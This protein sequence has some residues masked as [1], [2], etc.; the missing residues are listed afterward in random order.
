MMPAHFLSRLLSL[1][2]LLVGV[3]A[4]A[5]MAESDVPRFKESACPFVNDDL[6]DVVRCGYLVVAENRAVDNGRTLHLAVAIIRSSAASPRSDPIVYLSGGPGGKNVEYV[7]RRAD[8]FFWNRY[9]E[10]RD[11]VFFDQRGTGFSEPRFC[12]EL[13]VALSTAV[14]RGISVEEQRNFEREAVLECRAKMLAAGIDF[15][16]YNSATSARDLDELRQALGYESWNLFGV[17]YGTRLALT[18]M[19][20]TPGGVRSVVLDSVSPPGSPSADS[21]HKLMRTLRLVFDQCAADRRCHAA[22]PTLEADFFSVVD[23]LE[24][25]PV[26][27]AMTDPIRFPDA[28]I[29]IN[30]TVFVAG[31]FQGLYEQAFVPFLPILVRELKAGNESML[32][33]MADS[34][35][36]DPHFV[37]QG[38]RYA[39]DCY[40]H[41]PYATA[42][43]LAEDRA[44]HPQ[45]AVFHNLSD[46]QAIC[47]A[48]HSVRAGP[49][50]LQAATS[51]I[52]TLVAAGEFDPITPPSYARLA[53]ERLRNATLFEVRG[54]SHGV[55]LH[56][57]CAQGIMQ[58]FLD[59]PLSPPDT[60][61]VASLQR[62]DFVTSAHANPGVYRLVR[63]IQELPG[64]ATVVGLGAKF[65]LIGSA[66]LVWPIAWLSRRR[67]RDNVETP[68][69]ARQARTLE[70]V[71][72]LLIVVFLAGLAWAIKA[73]IQQNVYLLAIGVGASA[74]PLF[75]LPWIVALLTLV[76]SAFV[77][78]AWKHRWW[79]IIGRIYFSLVAVA[80]AGFVLWAV[81]LGLI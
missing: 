43:A 5:A 49:A 48:W 51:D 24:A 28:R 69:A 58:A 27:L 44:A 67:S 40:E 54:A 66:I 70:F 7:P 35:A 80:C 52:P 37:S 55:I 76:L 61:C 11:L 17:S 34:L 25:R 56:S 72:A 3:L 23:E 71:T 6:A 29:V 41:I 74:A 81:H 19:R 60:S 65:L 50:E 59:D 26:E 1:A 36:P 46:E 75:L 79:G 39:V 10:D 45:L 33:A 22:F 8:H 57:D 62:A 64:T 30:G 20:D 15:S 78:L 12:P 38:L 31:I 68:S 4:G 32:Y 21:N 73:A 14:F 13:T 18:A 63:Q 77:L 47:D 2:V 9:R 53:A 42:E 16:A